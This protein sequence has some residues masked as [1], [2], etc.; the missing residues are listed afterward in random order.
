MKNQQQ[1]KSTM[2]HKENEWEWKFVGIWV[3]MINNSELVEKLKGFI[4]QDTLLLF[5]PYEK[6]LEIIQDNLQHRNQYNQLKSGNKEKEL[7]DM[8]ATIQTLIEALPLTHQL[9]IYTLG[10]D[11]CI[12]IHV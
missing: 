9:C 3:D 8:N 1:N 5:K 7:S 12:T 10:A 4:L 6:V 2:I 11:D